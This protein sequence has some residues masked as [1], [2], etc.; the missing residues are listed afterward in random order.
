MIIL[1]DIECNSIKLP[2]PF[3][4]GK[5]ANELYGYNP[6]GHSGVV[7]LSGDAR[8]VIESIESDFSIHDL[9]IKM[10]SLSIDHY[11][12]SRI[13]RSLAEKELISL[14]K[15]YDTHLMNGRMATKRQVKR[16]FCWLQITDKCNLHCHYCY[17]NKKSS[18]LSLDNAK[19][20][21]SKIIQSARNSG[22]ESVVFKLAGGEPTLEWSKCRELIEWT[23]TNYEKDIDIRFSLLSNGTNIPKGFVETVNTYNIGISVSLDG[24]K[25]QH[26]KSRSY[27]MGKGS[28][29]DITNN[30]DHLLAN[31][32]SPFI[33]TTV[34][35]DNAFGLRVLADF[36]FQKR[37]RF[38]FSLQ[39]ITCDPKLIQEQNEIFIGGLTDCYNWM[40]SNLPSQSLYRCH[41]L[42]FSNLRKPHKR[43]C[44]M[45]VSNATISSTAEICLCQ[46]Y[47]L[48]K[49]LASCT[50]NNVISVIENQTRY[51]Q[52]Y[53]EVD[54][55]E[56]C[57]DCIW[58]YTCGGGCPLHR[59]HQYQSMDMPSPHCPVYKAILPQF[60]Q[61]H[62]AQ[63]VAHQKNHSQR[64]G[65]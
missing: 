12:F 9:A 56:T 53:I 14:G 59:L 18:S 41:K 52:K 62:A 47:D 20:V 49:P 63:L 3:I 65:D 60:I 48:T 17:I 36:C 23:Y 6:R 57:R 54:S 42:G 8:K 13:L 35:P 40:Q 32:I 45:G 55:M 26:D 44:G 64:G 5:I 10:N 15:A 38:R 19:S 16:F 30:I 2:D 61:L 33:L 11:K 21:V 28:F 51:N 22:C 34:T 37:L 4:L 29:E 31:G 25:E 24:F 58:R 50:T 7:L 1:D 43:V 39:R 46:Q 27:S